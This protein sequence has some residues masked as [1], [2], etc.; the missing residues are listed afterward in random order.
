[1]KVAIDKKV[2]SRIDITASID[3]FVIPDPKTLSDIQEDQDLYTGLEKAGKLTIN[4]ALGYGE[5]EVVV[6]NSGLDR[7][8][9][10][11]MMEGIDLSQIKRNPVVLWAHD[12]GALPIGQIVKLWRS[13]KDLM[14]RIKLDYDIYSFADIVYKMMLRGTI[15]AVSIGGIVQKWQDDDWETG[16][17]EK[18]EMVELSVV[19]VGAHPDALVVARSLNKPVEEIQKSYE[20]FL[21]KSIIDKTKGMADDDLNQTVITLEKLVATLKAEVIARNGIA[22]S[23]VKR[24]KLVTIRKTAQA[25]D[26]QTER[27][28]KIVKLKEAQK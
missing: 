16:V 25:V 18:L 11:I 13:N 12:Y 27:V 9:E 17:I 5:I 3:S 8:G 22:S 1:M 15:N 7:H 23:E 4:K 10:R 19:P 14:A 6:S 21:Q 2:G 24:V 20:D 26:Q 28:I